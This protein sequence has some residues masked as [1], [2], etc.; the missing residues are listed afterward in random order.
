MKIFTTPT[1]ASGYNPYGMY[2]EFNP[3]WLLVG[4]PPLLILLAFS[5]NYRRARRWQQKIQSHGQVNC[6]AC[7]YRGELLVRTLSAT[8]NSS[9]NLRLVCA[10]CNSSDWFIPEEEKAK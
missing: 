3:Y 9:S 5:M 8:N 4:I 7:G 10:Q 2:N 1:G 6:R